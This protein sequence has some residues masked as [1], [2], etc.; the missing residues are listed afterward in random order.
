M[1]AVYK[2][3]LDRNGKA[4]GD[5]PHELLR[6][7]HKTHSLHQAASQMSMSYSKAW[8]LIRTLEMRLGFALLK[9]RTGGLSGGGSRLTP[10]AKLLIEQYGRF[11]K[12]VD[13]TLKK[14]FH[15]HFGSIR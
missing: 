6:K 12:E 8:Q 1:K 4:F 9:S 14:I 10:E 5:G 7:V 11:R 13:G 15:K 2:I 3:W